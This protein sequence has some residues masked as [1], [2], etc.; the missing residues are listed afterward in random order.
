[1]STPHR[2]ASR[3]SWYHARVAEGRCTRCPQ[4]A[5]PGK[6]L[7]QACALIDSARCKA[8]YR[9][10]LERAAVANRA[11]ERARREGRT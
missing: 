6:V 2:L 10:R 4:P 1:M 9:R 3:Q 8:H 11:A 7:C 5:R